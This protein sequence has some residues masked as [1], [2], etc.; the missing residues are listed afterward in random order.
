[1]AGETWSRDFPGTG[2]PSG[3]PRASADAFVLKLD[4]SGRHVL[5]SVFPGGSGSDAARAIAVDA[6]G[7]AYV[8]GVTTS[9]DFPV[10]PGA[11]QRTTASV[12][13]EE[14][15]VLKLDPSGVVVWATYLGGDKSD[16]AYAIAVD[17]AGAAYVTGS[18]N[19]TN[20]PTS[21]GA[22]QRTLGGASDCFVSKLDASG[23]WLAYSTYLGGEDIDSC[24]GIAVDAA[25]AAF[26]TGST[27]SY[28]FPLAAALRTTPGGGLDAFVAKLSP[29]GDRLIFS[30]YLGGEGADL[31]EAVAVEPAGTVLVGG[32]TASAGF[33]VTVGAA[34]PGWSGNYD[35][36]ICRL[37]ADGSRVLFATF[38][39]GRGADSVT[40]LA[41]APGGWIAAAGYT[42]ST[43]F[44]VVNPAQAGFGGAFDAFVAILPADGSSLKVST[45]L[46]GSGDDRAAGVAPLGD[47]A[48]VAGGFTVSGSAAVLPNQFTSPAA[49]QPD[50]FAAVIAYASPAASGGLRF[51][52]ITPCRVADTRDPAGPFG[53][54]AMA[55]GTSRDFTIPASA[56]GV[57]A[58]AQAYSLNVT[59]VPLGM[60]GYLTI[61]P[62]GPERPAASVLNS[63]DGR[64]KAN[65]AI[66]PAGTGGAV[67]VYASHSTHVV[68]DVNGYFVSAGGA[69][70][71]AYYPLVPCRIADTRDADGPLGGPFVAAG[72]SRSFPVQ[73]SQCGIPATAQAYML[74]FTA[75]PKHLLGYITTWPTGRPK[76]VASTLNAVTG[77]VTANAAIVPTG[78]AGA[79]DTYASHDTNLI[80]DISGY[81]APPEPGGLSL[82]TVAPC[83]ELDTRGSGTWL[84]GGTATDLLLTAC[85]VPPTAQAYVLNATVIPPGLMGYLSLWP[86]GKAKPLASA[87]NAVDGMITSN[88]ALI[89]SANGTITVYPSHPAH[90]LL[91]LSGYFAP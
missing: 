80:I 31:G 15:F 66:V 55:G 17:A 42:A 56:C 21:A 45:C 29:A 61:W 57:P 49:G 86:Q 59:V 23:G 88:M 48:F 90:L 58:S 74:N 87:L 33:P 83:R 1:L 70:T 63:L 8:A 75:V 85:T 79:I 22:P 11:A 14:A 38:L 39:G 65:A 72:Q 10:T 47:Y 53:G 51:V 64:V 18:T 36:F 71:L 32:A 54:P 16:T 50:G 4:S 62:T 28:A 26:V 91:D 52:P 73:G 12:G 84:A 9:R 60:L 19:S 46:G 3:S 89:P 20:L 34:Q 44:P 2:L 40:A 27:S 69:D 67:S 77:T 35:G 76:P 24:K 78:T 41:V 37:A 68:L 25:G 81:F 82:Y 30:T 5:Y 43:D 7:N 6:A 13:V